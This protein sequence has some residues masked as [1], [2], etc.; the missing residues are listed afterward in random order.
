MKNCKSVLFLC[1]FGL[2]I[3]QVTAQE[4][5]KLSFTNDGWAY[6]TAQIK[7]VKGK[8]VK[9][10]ILMIGD[11][12]GLTQ[13]STA[14]VA[15][16]GHLFLDNFT[17]TGLSRTTA[18]N[19]LITDS[20]AAGT[21][22]ATG[23][24]TTYHSVGVDT[25]GN[26]LSSLSKLAHKKGLATGIMVTCGITDATPAAFCANNADREQ[27]EEL[28]T[29]YVNCTVDYVFGGGSGF[30]TKRTDNRNLL[31]EI[32]A[33]GYQTPTTWAETK[34][35]TKGKIFALLEEGQLPLAVERGTLFQ[36]GV[37]HGINSLSKNKKGFFAMVE[38]SR[39]D[40][41]GHWNHLPQLM[42]EMF[43]FD[44]TIGKI[45]Q[46][47]EKDGQTLVILLADHETGGL[48][49][50]DG[51]VKR[52]F[53]KG[54]FSTTGHSGI[55]VPVY[56]FGPKAELFTGLYENTEVFQKIAALLKLLK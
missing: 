6:P 12:M 13:V 53:V 38:G 36:E 37:M 44:K 2:F 16:K 7:P 50:L 8:K 55:Q 56:A 52:G 26:P 22:I 28:A 39:I 17:C 31:E 48:T 34:K 49:L 35:I 54:N 18:A 41:C 33:N 27:E 40:D 42:H 45:L 10:V 9:N 1:L 19:K 15:N 20:G 23:Q 21:A 11:G 29:D 25:S 30:F 24:K 51:D 14:W 46:W 5:D 32:R 4:V 3:C 43:D 47:A